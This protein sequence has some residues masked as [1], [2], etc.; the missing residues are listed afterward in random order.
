M[1]LGRHLI[2]GYLAPEG[3]G[4]LRICCKTSTVKWSGNCVCLEVDA[5]NVR[6]STSAGRAATPRDRY[7]YRDFKPRQGGLPK[8]DR[9]Y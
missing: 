5:N 1:V 2:L 6:D 8:T 9:D 4:M 3:Q 7:S